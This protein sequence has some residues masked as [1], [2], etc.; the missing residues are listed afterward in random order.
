MWTGGKKAALRIADAE[1]EKFNEEI[2]SGMLECL[3]KLQ[4]ISRTADL[5]GSAALRAIATRP[6]NGKE[7]EIVVVLD[8]HPVVMR[9]GEIP[10]QAKG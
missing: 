7:N 2:R 5:E 8:V 3:A 9:A 6:W 10:V 1:R 4:D